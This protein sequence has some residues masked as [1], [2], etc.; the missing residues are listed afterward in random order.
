MEASLKFP[1]FAVSLFMSAFVCGITNAKDMVLTTLEGTDLTL[2][3]DSTWVY[4]SGTQIDVKEDFTVPVDGGKFVLIASDGT[5]GFVKKEIKKEKE[6]IPADSVIGKGHAV[7]ID[8][9][10][11]TARAQNE[12]ISTVITKMKYALRNVKIDPKKLSDCVKRVEKDVDKKE[13]FIKGTGWDVAIVIKLDRGSIL[14]VADC[15]MKD[16]VAPANKPADSTA[17]AK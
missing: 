6:I 4:K 8:V 1:T 11:A 9:A 5:W 15:S 3:D 12:A 2:K 14:A 16:A 7:H 17:P 13:T 10:V